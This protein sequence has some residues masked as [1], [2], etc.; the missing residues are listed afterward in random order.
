MITIVARP[1]ADPDRLEEVKAAL[2]DLVEATLKEE[3]CLC[4][5]LHQDNEHPNR[6]VFVERW[7]NRKLWRQHM[8][9]EGVRAFNARVSGGIIGF[10]LQELTKVAG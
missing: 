6:F 7:E 5:E 9:G 2:V 10:E 8:A 3:G 4:Y 1:T